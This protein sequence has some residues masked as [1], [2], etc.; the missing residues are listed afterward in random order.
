MAVH[1]LQG[2]HWCRLARKARKAWGFAGWW[3]RGELVSSVVKLFLSVTSFNNSP[4]SVQAGAF[5]FLAADCSFSLLVM[6]LLQI[7]GQGEI[8]ADHLGCLHEDL[9]RRRLWASTCCSHFCHQLD[10][11][12]PLQRCRLWHC[13]HSSGSVKAAGAIPCDPLQE[14]RSQGFMVIFS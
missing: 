3:Q 14:G 2:A 11:C 8:A 9:G 5:T 10:G 12:P 1:Y 6:C 7:V 13:Q 4:V